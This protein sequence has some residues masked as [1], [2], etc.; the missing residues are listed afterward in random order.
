MNIEEA[1]EL[2][3]N[4]VKSFRENE[5]LMRY[6]LVPSS[7]EAIETILEE[8]DK[9]DKEYQEYMTMCYTTCRYRKYED[10]WHELKEYCENE[11]F[12][13]AEIERDTLWNTRL[14]M[15]EIEQKYLESEMGE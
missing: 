4:D 11:Q 8:L 6:V 13:A 9:K 15:C 3:R 2:L 5:M 14:K 7:V 1:K 12:G 10:M